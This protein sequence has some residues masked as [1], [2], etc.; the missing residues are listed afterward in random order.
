MKLFILYSAHIVPEI[1]DIVTKA[2]LEGYQFLALDVKS[3][4]LL[5][6][7]AIDSFHIEDFLDALEIAQIRKSAIQF[8]KNF[9]YKLY[10]EVKKNSPVD[11]LNFYCYWFEFFLQKKLAKAFKRKNFHNIKLIKFQNAG[12]ALFESP[13]ETFGNL[14]DRY[15][16]VEFLKS[17]YGKI[18]TLKRL[19]HKLNNGLKRFSLTLSHFLTPKSRYQNPFLIY[20]SLNEYVYF[21]NYIKDLQLNFGKRRVLLIIWDVN[22]FDALKISIRDKVMIKYFPIYDIYSQTSLKKNKNLFKLIPK[23]DWFNFSY[24]EENRF[25]KYQSFQNFVSREIKA[26]SPCAIIVSSI[27]SIENS[28]M[29]IEAKKANCKSF[30]FSHGALGFSKLGL[31]FSDNYCVGNEFASNIA[32]YETKSSKI[33]LVEGID[34][35][36][37]YTMENEYAI[38]KQKFNILLLSNPYM[39][40]EETRVTFDPKLGIKSQIQAFKDVYELLSIENAEII[41]KTHP[42]WPEFEIIEMANPSLIDKACS[43]N[44]SL[45]DLLNKVDLVIGLNYMGGALNGC[46]RNNLP[47][48]FYN[49]S[50]FF[51]QDKDYFSKDLR[52][53]NNY[54]SFINDRNELIT[55]VQECVKS[56]DKILKLS[57]DTSKFRTRYFSNNK[58][59]IQLREILNIDS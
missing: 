58:Q 52:V 5:F 29:C 32:Q 7:M 43:P 48:V 35:I 2:K 37:E 19:K 13:S 24:F 46:V 45:I 15:I 57:K 6:K 17:N 26:I 20:C 14:F 12:P 39:S 22:F 16:E 44:T 9:I 11:S 4:Y 55:F 3:S 21:K 34:P 42:G 27:E 41:I 47:I 40:S 30:S 49:T 56:S 51:D 38:D 50:P 33:L 18:Q 54:F 31:S 10:P 1:E 59:H 53:L 8:S 23:N 28:I 25:P 36:E